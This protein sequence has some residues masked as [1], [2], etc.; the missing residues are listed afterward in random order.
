MGLSIRIPMDLLGKLLWEGLGHRYD[1]F[2]TFGQTI[3]LESFPFFYVIL[4]TMMAT[5]FQTLFVG[6]WIMHSSVL[7]FRNT[8]FG[9]TASCVGVMLI[10]VANAMTIRIY[11]REYNGFLLGK[12][13]MIGHILLLLQA[14][15]YVLFVWLIYHIAYG[16]GVLIGTTAKIKKTE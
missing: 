13:C 15:L 3:V 7:S 8:S 6:I 9:L 10:V 1:L 5:I 4:C 14:N 16:L 2:E 12:E 11:N